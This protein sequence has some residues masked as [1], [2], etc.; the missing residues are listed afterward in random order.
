VGAPSRVFLLFPRETL[1][2]LSLFRE[3][4]EDYFVED[5]NHWKERYCKLFA[6]PLRCTFRAYFA[7]PFK[8]PFF[9]RGNYAVWRDRDSLCPPSLLGLFSVVFFS[10]LRLQPFSVEASRRAQAGRR[11]KNST[12][13]EH[14]AVFLSPLAVEIL[15]VLVGDPPGSFGFLA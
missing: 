3:R 13:S 4:V 11:Y 5:V 7:D 9:D 1:S 14:G 12:L 10:P 8:E 2:T 15:T 6:T